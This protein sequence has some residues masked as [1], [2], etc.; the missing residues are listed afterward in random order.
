M[1]EEK[2]G[3]VAQWFSAWLASKSRQSNTWVGPAQWGTGR[4]EAVGSIPT[5]PKGFLDTVPRTNPAAQNDFRTVPPGGNLRT[6]R[7]WRT[8]SR[9]NP[10]SERSQSPSPVSKN[11]VQRRPDS[12]RE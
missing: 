6:Y 7:A 1:I 11:T 3:D 5:V 9:M 8:L 12:R 4:E 2:K 10:V